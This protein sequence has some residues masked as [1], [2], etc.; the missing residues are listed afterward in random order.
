MAAVVSAEVEVEVAMTP[1]MTLVIVGHDVMDHLISQTKSATTA[2]KRVTFLAS[3]P[4]N[5]KEVVVV[6]V[7]VALGAVVAEIMAV[8][9]DL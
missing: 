7:T 4:T 5:R 1:Q 2:T 6:A 9:A 3:A 8:N